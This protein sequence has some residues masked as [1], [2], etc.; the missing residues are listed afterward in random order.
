[1]FAETKTATVTEDE[2]LHAEGVQG[3]RDGNVDNL[4]GAAAIVNPHF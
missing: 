4:N 3:Q 2:H 1:M